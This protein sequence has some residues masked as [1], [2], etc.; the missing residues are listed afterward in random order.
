MKRMRKVLVICEKPDAAAKIAAALSDGSPEKGEFKGVPF[1][2]FQREGKEVLVAPALGHLFT[3]KNK[4][5]M[6]D[7]PIYEVD[8][9][10]AY[11][12]DKKAWRTKAFIQAIGELAK[13]C[14]EYIVATDFDVEGSVI[15][16]SVL[17][18][19]CGEEALSKARRMKFSTLTTEDL[20]RAYEEMMPCLD[21]ELVEAGIAR[22]T[23]D[24]YWGMNISLALSMALR[25]VEQRFAKLSA[26]RVQTPTLKILV[27]REREISS[28]RPQPFWVLTLVLE[29]DGK[30]AVAEHESERFF[31]QGEAQRALEAC[32]GEPALV[33]SIQKRKYQ[34]LPPVPFDLGTLQSEAYNLF[35]Y[36]PTKTQQLAQNL[37]LAGL[38]SYP[39]TSSQKLPVSINYRRIIE[40]LSDIEAYAGMTRELLSRPTLVPREG[41]KTDPAHPAIFPTGEKP[42]KPLGPSRK[43]YDLIVRRFF[44]VFAEPSVVES[45]RIDLDVGGERFIL[46]G[47]RVLEEGWLRYYGKYG[48]KE[49]HLLPEVKEGEKLEVKEVKLEERETQPPP[50]YNP[51]SIIKEM[52]ARNLGTKSTRAGILQNLYE[53]GY[54]YGN[55][56]AV[57]ELGTKVVDSLAKYCLE[58]ASEELT[59]DF[60]REMDAIQEGRRSRE[61]VIRRAREELDKI[62]SKF[63]RH[64]REIGIQLAEAYRITRLKQRMLGRCPRCGGNLLLVVSKK[65]RKRFASCSNYPNC[66]VSF[67][68]PQAGLIISLNKA[69]E[70]CGL[71]VIQVSKPGMRPYRMCLGPEC[72]SKEGWGR[73]NR[74]KP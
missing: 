7:Y 41:E 25:A 13:G 2:R 45:I 31:E 22:H 50:R 5:P 29:L 46:R 69:C 37:Y 53:R 54:I 14:S 48:E 1:Y 47:R 19:I 8:W 12:A 72:N 58:I 17:K 51:A 39:R 27:E 28:F 68:L 24:W 56:I 62:L 73:K 35:G 52:E 20:R 15:G 33:T 10:P 70:H 4:R 36:T 61:D 42:E 18:Y 43:L 59:A 3:L 30:E 6:K 9:V 63:K 66:R 57:T 32:R 74:E 23:L 44:S 38:I 65:T 71:P 55:Q 16:W 26:G 34:R 67:P 49:E 64:Q 60:E 21:F 40:K 11:L